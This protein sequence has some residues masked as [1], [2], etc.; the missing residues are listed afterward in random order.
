MTKMMID[1]LSCMDIAKCF[2]KSPSWVSM[3]TAI[4]GLRRNR[5]PGSGRKKS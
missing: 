4:F 1:G 5:K 3:M 2:G